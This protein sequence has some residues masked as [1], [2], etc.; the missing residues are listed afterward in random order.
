MI[1]T[2]LIAML[3]VLVASNAVAQDNLLSNSNLNSEL[4]PWTA[5]LSGAPDPVGS[6]SITWAGLINSDNVMNGSGSAQVALSA[7][8]TTTPANASS[9]FRQCVALPDPLFPAAPT[10]VTSANY[11]AHFLIPATGNA[12]DGLANATIEVRF[13]SDGNCS[14]F[15]PG[16]GGTQGM[17]LTS[18]ALN[19]IVW[20][21]L[22]ESN[23]SMPSGAVT[24]SSAEVRAFLR[25]TGT[26]SNR[27]IAYFDR[28]F[29]AINGGLP[30]ELVRFSVD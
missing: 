22:E 12:S 13:F 8:S 19:D 27:Y 5:T 15:I 6:G 9:G 11:G 29:L 3:F 2:L 16:A 30:V 23:L 14:A 21:E 28:I 20:Y 18:L 26:T 4:A 17:V 10:H 25:T 1:Q 7:P 24:A